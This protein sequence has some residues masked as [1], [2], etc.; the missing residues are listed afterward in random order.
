MEGPGTVN[1]YWSSDYAGLRIDGLFEFYYGYEETEPP[2]SPER[3]D[4]KEGE[5]CFVVRRPLYPQ[6]WKRVRL[7]SLTFTQLKAKNN[8]LDQYNVRGCL[9]QGIGMFLARCKV[10]LPEDG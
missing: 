1:G 6:H 5:W 8:C 7:F 3:D 9:M 2:R 10:T 4:E